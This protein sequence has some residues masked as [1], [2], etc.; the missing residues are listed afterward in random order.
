MK[1]WNNAGRPTSCLSRMTHPDYP[2]HENLRELFAITLPLVHRFFEEDS[3]V[4][5]AVAAVEKLEMHSLP[6]PSP[7]RTSGGEMQREKWSR[8]ECCERD[9]GGRGREGRWGRREGKQER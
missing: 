8:D 7:P 6:S 9:R 5:A 1:T 3:K 2:L 4:I